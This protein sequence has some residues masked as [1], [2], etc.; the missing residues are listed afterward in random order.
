MERKET[1]LGIIIPSSNTTVEPEFAQMLH[2]LPWITVHT[3][4][5]P[6]AEVTPKSL[7]K[8]VKNIKNAAHLL[9]DASVDGICLACTSA[10]FI[11]SRDRM[12]NIKK[13]IEHTTGVSF[14]TTSECVVSAIKTLRGQRSAL[15]TPYIPELNSFEVKFLEDAVKGLKVVGEKGFN[16][17]SNL[18]IGKLP[19]D[20]ILHASRTLVSNVH[21]DVL[22]L[23]CTNMPSIELIQPLEDELGIPVISSNSASLFGLLRL[24][25]QSLIIEG[26]GKLLRTLNKL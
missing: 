23:S 14:I 11:G 4:R 20:R 21:P 6:L 19:S 13:D 24:L 17:T 8:M 22:F 2:L 18:K 26:F 15:V 10:S 25:N 12:S 16:L 7:D 9:V 1:R 5:L 3:T